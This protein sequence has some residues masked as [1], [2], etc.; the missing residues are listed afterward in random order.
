MKFGSKTVFH[1]RP[2]F[3]IQ[4][5]TLNLLNNLQPQTSQ[6]LKVHGEIICLSKPN[7][8]VSPLLAYRSFDLFPLK[9]ESP[10]VKIVND[11][12]VPF[13]M[14]CAE[15]IEIFNRLKNVGEVFHLI[16]VPLKSF[17]NSY[18][19]RK[20]G[21]VSALSFLKLNGCNKLSRVIYFNHKC[22]DLRSNLVQG[23]EVNV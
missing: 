13:A 8:K 3:H 19:F 14:S 11:K 5:L 23:R 21:T 1:E 7:L 6:K 16:G 2:N 22:K 4:T 17:T 10:R 20:G 12:R 15:Y 9:S 18:M